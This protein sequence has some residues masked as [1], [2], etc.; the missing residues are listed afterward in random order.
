MTFVASL[1]VAVFQT[2]KGAGGSLEIGDLSYEVGGL[3]SGLSCL[4][5]QLR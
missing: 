4:S 5:E 2:K 3:L 1:K